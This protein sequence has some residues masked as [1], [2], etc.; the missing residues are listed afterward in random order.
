VATR[1]LDSQ[2]NRP[3]TFGHPAS[4]PYGTGP[5]PMAI[6]PSQVAHDAVQGIL[7]D[8]PIVFSLPAHGREAFRSQVQELWRLTDDALH[9]QV[10]A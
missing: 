2:R 6:E 3:E 7:R 4:E 9:D 10:E 1:I 8:A 5:I